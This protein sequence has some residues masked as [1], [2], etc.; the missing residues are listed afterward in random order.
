MPTAPPDPESPGVREDASEWGL[1]G[2]YSRNLADPSGAQARARAWA[3]ENAAAIEAYNRL[4]EE[5]GGVG[6]DLRSW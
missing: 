2:A 4:V 5:H 6:D 3:S 1:A